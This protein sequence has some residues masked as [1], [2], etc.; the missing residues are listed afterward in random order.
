MEEKIINEII[1]I[2]VKYK[3]NLCEAETVLF[4][5]K[6]NFGDLFVAKRKED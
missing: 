3:L 4:K 5:V 6:K 2:I 1:E